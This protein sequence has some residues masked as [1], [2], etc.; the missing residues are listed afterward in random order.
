MP[1]RK[2]CWCRRT[3]SRKRR[4]TRLRTTAPP[5]LREVM[6]PTRHRPE[7]STALALSSSSL[8]RHTWPSRFTCSYS[9]PRVKRRCFGNESEV[10][11][12]IRFSV[13]YY[14]QKTFGGRPFRTTF[15]ARRL[16]PV[17]LPTRMGTAKVFS[18][19]ISGED[20][21]KGKT[22]GLTGSVTSQEEIV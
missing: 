20:F 2:S 5:S 1:C 22:E 17:R 16:P 15:P 8:P 12:V 21:A 10:A 4:R 14:R 19:R 7:F 9:E 3:I 13:R 18:R 11:R 6:N